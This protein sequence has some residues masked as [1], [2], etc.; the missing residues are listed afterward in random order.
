M[1]AI[2]LADSSS[3][4]NVDIKPSNSMLEELE[5]ADIAL[6]VLGRAGL[7]EDEPGV[8]A[9]LGRAGLVEDEPGVGAV[10]GRVGQVEDEPGVGAVLGR[11]GLVEDEPGIGAVLGR[12]VAGRAVVQGPE[13]P[14][15][16]TSL[17]CGFLDSAQTRVCIVCTD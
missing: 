11:A 13:V 6:A 16:T 5:A 1:A 2:C 14:T 7:V 3:P 9:V 10:L 15:I 12:E 8:G 17:L 4:T